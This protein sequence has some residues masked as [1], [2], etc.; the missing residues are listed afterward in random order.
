MP[1]RY[2]HYFRMLH[3]A[4]DQSITAALASM[5]LTSAQGHV[6]GFIAHR[7][8]PPCARDIE[9]AF[10]MSHP[11]VSGILSRLEK[12]GFIEFRPDEEDHRCKRI[13]MLDKGMEIIETMHRTI[14]HNE[15]RLVQNFTEEEKAIF[16]DLLLRAI[17]NMGY[18]ACKRKFKEEKSTHD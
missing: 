15:H 10:R 14:E 16:A 13:F 5:D 11:T 3:S 18:S 6:I 9:Q 2:G 7:P 1:P 8:Q 4:T 12:K 17:D